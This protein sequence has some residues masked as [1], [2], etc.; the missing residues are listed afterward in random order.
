MWKRSSVSSPA[1][2]ACEYATHEGA[3]A[4]DHCGRGPIEEGDATPDGS[5]VASCRHHGLVA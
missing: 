1:I 4:R 2:A 5:G 3:L